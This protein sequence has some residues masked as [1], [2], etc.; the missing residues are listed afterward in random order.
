MC[1]HLSPQRIN[2]CTKIV[3][4]RKMLRWLHLGLYN[5][6]LTMVPSFG[7]RHSLLRG[8]Y[9]M[10][11]GEST[12]LEMGTRVFSPQ[13]ISIGDNSVIHFDCILDGRLGL[14]IGNCVDVGIQTH[15]WTLQHDIDDPDYATIG[16]QV[17]IRDYAVIGGRSTILPG[18]TVGEGA[19]VASGAVVT[20]DVLPYTL[21]AGVP[22][23]YIRERERNLKYKISYRRYF[24]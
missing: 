13:R 2:A 15:I 7:M 24:H 23:R 10:K 4:A 8:L 18:V 21:V 11:I 12:N 16:G 19:V 9:G 14:I 20:K 6:F 5:R 22:A 1:H 3:E 17:N